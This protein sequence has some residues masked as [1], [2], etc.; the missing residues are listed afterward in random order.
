MINAVTETSTASDDD[1]DDVIAKELA[2]LQPATRANVD[3]VV[4][5]LHDGFREF[6]ASGRIWDRAAIV[7]ALAAAPGRGAD[8]EDVRAVRLAPDVIHLTYVARRPD[9]ASLRSSLWL[10][11]TAGW[12]LLFHQGT[13]CGD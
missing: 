13:P 12:R 4:E 7:A 6:G 11:D 8:A 5:L 3:A 10:R 9:R 2:L 1:V